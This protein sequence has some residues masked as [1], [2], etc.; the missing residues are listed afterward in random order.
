L[1]AQVS[2][3]HDFALF[4]FDHLSPFGFC[5]SDQSLFLGTISWGSYLISFLICG[6]H[7]NR[8]VQEKNHPIIRLTATS[9]LAFYLRVLIRAV[10][11]AFIKERRPDENKRGG[12]PFLSQ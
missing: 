11:F 8:T 3:T 10:G 2:K 7:F 9:N 12:F 6:G 4:A 1:H 5:L